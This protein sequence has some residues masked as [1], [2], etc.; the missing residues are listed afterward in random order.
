MNSAGYA[1]KP[2]DEFLLG[3]EAI[4]RG[5][6]EAGVKV[7]AAYAGTPSTEITEALA[8]FAKGGSDIYVEWS[9]NEK[10]AVETAAAGSFAGL[11]A[12]SAM[13]HAGLNVAMDFLLHLNYSEIG[14]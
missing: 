4:A 3:N 7:C 9:T 5:A 12:F 13:K 2:D 11:R 10:V 6:L 1:P 8:E 14:G